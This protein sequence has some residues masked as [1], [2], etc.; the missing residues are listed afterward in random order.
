M[1]EMKMQDRKFCQSQS[2]T[3]MQTWVK[4]RRDVNRIETWFA[5]DIFSLS[6][7]TFIYGVTLFLS[8]LNWSFVLLQSLEKRRTNDFTGTLLWIKPWSFSVFSFSGIRS[9]SPTRKTWE[10]H[11]ID[12]LYFFLWNY[13]L[14]SRE[15]TKK[16][17]E[18][19][20][21]LFFKLGNYFCC[22]TNS[23]SLIWLFSVSVSSSILLSCECVSSRSTLGRDLA[24]ICLRRL[25]GN[26]GSSMY[27]KWKKKTNDMEGRKTR[28]MSD[29]AWINHLRSRISRLFQGKRMEENNSVRKISCFL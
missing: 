13:F 21:Q 20:Q 29:F 18:H 12:F 19:Q 5:C 25:T 15:G 14:T 11:A 16:R 28:G 23:V 6:R 7:V 1:T 26:K 2:M 17:K 8:S 22:W 10:I 3:W 4:P 27:K 24:G 9:F